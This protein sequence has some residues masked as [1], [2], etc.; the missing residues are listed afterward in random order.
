MQKINRTYLRWLIVAGLIEGCSTLV[1]FFVAMPMK[2]YADIP[3]AVSIVGM[4]HGLLFIWLVLMFWFG[5]KIVPLPTNLMWFG[6]AGAVIPFL[7][8]I[9]D[10]P[11]YRIL[12]GSRD[13]VSA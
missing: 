13:E 4:I 11:L 8:F 7:P 6:M 5:R 12:R 2:Y 3:E 1:L 9:V 10:I